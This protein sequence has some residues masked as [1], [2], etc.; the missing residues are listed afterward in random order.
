MKALIAYF[1][2]K[3]NNYV[4]GDIVD[5][6]VG[7]TEVAARKLQALTGGDLFEIRTKR[8]YAADYH[9]CTE[10]ALRELRQDERPELAATVPALDAYDTVFLGFPNWWGTMP[11]AV[12]T[13]LESVDL[14]GKTIR[15]F[16]TNEGSGMGRSES[17]LR[18]L[19]PSADIKAGLSLH[20][21]SVK[22][23]DKDIERWLKKQ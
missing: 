9:V 21:G 22:S 6:P 20:G 17:D 3:G 10:E 4:S 13:W 15:P 1:S 23:A 11:M 8:A 18:R 14:T 7:N 16:C 19:Y 2:R 5:L 12:F